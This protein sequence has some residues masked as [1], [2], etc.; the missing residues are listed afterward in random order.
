MGNWFIDVG[1]TLNQ[2]VSFC[3]SCD[4][5]KVASHPSDMSSDTICTHWL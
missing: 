4:I 1:G 5:N 2:H 3:L